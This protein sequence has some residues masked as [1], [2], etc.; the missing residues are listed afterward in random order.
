MKITGIALKN[1]I[2]SAAILSASFMFSLLIQNLFSD[3]S[4]IPA[5]FVLAVFLISLITGSYVCGI[6]SSFISVLAVNFAFTFPYFKFNFTVPE[7]L[8][9]AVI[10][11]IVTILTSTLT[12]K[13]NIQEKI[14][15][16][17]EKEKMRANLL[18]AVSHDLRTPLTT[19][20]GSCSAIIENYDRIAKERQIKLLKEIQEDAQW[21]IQMVE[22]LLSVTRID[23]EKVNIKKNP[24]VLEELIDS[25]LIKFRKRYPN[26]NV[27][28]DIP[29]EFISI[30][31]DA[32]LI[33]QV[34]INLLENAVQHLK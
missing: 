15:T 18:R 8:V 9:S 12:T 10:M 6:V 5:L 24:T 33:E 17:G 4:L 34:I 22:N 19:I 11:L 2:V 30:P 13:I 1:V 3:Q 14:K 16:E 27:Y 20:Y 28:T 21:L 26:Q 25:V 29:D 32:M 23:K 7:N 31:M